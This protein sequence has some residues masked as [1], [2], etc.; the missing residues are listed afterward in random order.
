MPQ[1]PG[2]ADHAAPK[3]PLVKRIRKALTAAVGMAATL[4]AAGVL[5]DR[6]EAVVTAI[7]GVLTAYGVYAVPNAQSAA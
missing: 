6:A 5:D 7:L 4:T 3:P 1:I 2:V